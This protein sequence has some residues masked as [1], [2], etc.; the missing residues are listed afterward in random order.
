MGFGIQCMGLADSTYGVF[1]GM[2]GFRI[3]FIVLRVGLM[4]LSD[5]PY[6]LL[7]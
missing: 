1:G 3:V 6:W 2:Y 7:G 5:S 4:R